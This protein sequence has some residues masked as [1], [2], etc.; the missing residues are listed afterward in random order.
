MDVHT[1]SRP[2]SPELAAKAPR[3]AVLTIGCV[4]DPRPCRRAIFA[5]SVRRRFREDL[6][7]KMSGGTRAGVATA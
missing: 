4:F 1:D 6:L 5:G 3:I 7:V 2:T